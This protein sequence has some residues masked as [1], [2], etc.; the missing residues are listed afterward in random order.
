MKG[1]TALKIAVIGAILYGIYCMQ[2]DRSLTDSSDEL[3]ADRE[4]F[5]KDLEEEIKAAEAK[6]VELETKIAEAEAKV[7]AETAEKAE[8]PLVGMPNPMHHLTADEFRANCGKELNFDDIADDHL[9]YYSIDGEK[10]LYGIQLR[11]ADCL[12]YEFRMLHGRGD[13]DISGMY[14]EWTQEIKYP[15]KKPECTVYLNDSGQGICLWKDRSFRYSLA[16]KEGASLV[17]LV[18]MRKRIMAV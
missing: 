10:T 12:E 15:E 4:Q 1:K 3:D 2:D 16:M 8:E 11:D 5:R 13:A 6:A 18:W 9:Y 17:K 7:E 14:Y